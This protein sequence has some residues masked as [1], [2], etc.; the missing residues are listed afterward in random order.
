MLDDHQKPLSAQLIE[1]L[2]G[3]EHALQLQQDLIELL[4]DEVNVNLISADLLAVTLNPPV[5]GLA[6]SIWIRDSRSYTIT[7]DSVQHIT[8][9]LESN[10]AIAF[11]H[12]II[13]HGGNGSARLSLIGMLWSVK[14]IVDSQIRL[15]KKVKYDS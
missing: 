11:R 5:K 1:N 9:T 3:I 2:S 10:N 7:P 13:V 4:P 15:S 12:R 14:L 8:T 6:F